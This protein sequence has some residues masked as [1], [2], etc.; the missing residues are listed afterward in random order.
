M[1][2]YAK[3][4]YGQDEGARRRI[5]AALT[6]DDQGNEHDQSNAPDATGDQC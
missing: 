6:Q 4:I 2:V 5:E 3:C 1:R